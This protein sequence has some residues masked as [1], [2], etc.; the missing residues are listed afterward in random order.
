[1][2][3]QAETIPVDPDA[4]S[5][6]LWPQHVRM[7]RHLPKKEKKLASIWSNG[8]LVNA[9]GIK[10]NRKKTGPHRHADGDNTG[11][12]DVSVI[13]YKSSAVRGAAVRN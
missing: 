5:W 10:K 13:N 2:D 11:S 6:Q 1:M 12:E 8:N 4:S 9:E 7:C 3:R